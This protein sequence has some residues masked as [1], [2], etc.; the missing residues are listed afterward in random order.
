M[1]VFQ[2]IGFSYIIVAIIHIIFERIFIIMSSL[3]NFFKQN[4]KVKENTLYPATESLLDENGKPLLW[5]I[6][7]ITSKENDKIQDECTIEVQDKSGARKFKIDNSNYITKLICKSVVC[8]DLLNAELQDSYGVKTP[9]DLIHEMIDGA[10]EWNSLILFI[11][12]FNGFNISLDEK[13]EEIK[14]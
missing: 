1:R 10:G 2:Y 4:K 9:E 12:K 13:A 8:P 5:E 6:R 3:S 11:N 7:P 14:N